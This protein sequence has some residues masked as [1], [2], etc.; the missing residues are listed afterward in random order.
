MR[1]KAQDVT[2][3]VTH[4]DKW[5][6]DKPTGQCTCVKVAGCNKPC[7][8]AL[9]AVIF[10]KSQTVLG[11]FLVPRAS[12]RRCRV[13]VKESVSFVFFFCPTLCH[14]VR[15]KMKGLREGTGGRGRRG[16]PLLGLCW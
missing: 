15:M 9:R 2:S 14:V 13:G 4:G 10:W 1:P 8:G 3:S 6:D 12:H 11:C 7:H 16:L 5:S